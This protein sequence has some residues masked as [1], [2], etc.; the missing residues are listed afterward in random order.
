MDFFSPGEHIEGSYLVHDVRKS[1]TSV[2]YSCHDEIFDRPVAIKT[3][4]YDSAKQLKNSV[5]IFVPGAKRWILAGKDMGFVEAYMCEAGGFSNV[6][7]LAMII[8]LQD[9]GLLVNKTMK[10]MDWEAI[11]GD[12]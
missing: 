11:L 1:G 12:E 4:Q 5:E 9:L 8:R 6:S 10:R 3:P 7:K 2:V